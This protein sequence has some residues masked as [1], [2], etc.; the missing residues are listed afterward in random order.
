MVIDTKLLKESTLS[1][2]MFVALQAL[3]EADEELLLCIDRA[4]FLALEHKGYI[5][6]CGPNLVSDI[7]LRE[8]AHL[9][10]S[11]KTDINW[12][13]AWREIFPAGVNDVGFRYRGNRIECIK[14]MEKF[15]KK[16]RA[17]TPEIVIKATKQYVN[18]FEATNYKFMLL[19]HYFIEKQGI[20]STLAEECDNLQE[21]TPNTINTYG[22][23]IV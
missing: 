10:F 5:K 14:K 15:L 4:V 16:Y 17:F 19:A 7:E 18:R 6:I 8:R 21:E 9:L 2:S 20:G 3:I 1:I 23:T 22:R 13:D 12:I 11:K